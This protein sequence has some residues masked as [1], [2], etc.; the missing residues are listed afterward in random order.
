MPIR[1]NFWPNEVRSSMLFASGRW[2]QAYA[3]ELNRVN[4]MPKQVTTDGHD[5]Y[6]RAIREVLGPNVQHRCSAPE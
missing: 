2:V 4:T 3:P 5:S 6:P 1:P